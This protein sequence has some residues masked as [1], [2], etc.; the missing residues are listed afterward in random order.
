MTC[1]E[2][3]GANCLSCSNFDECEKCDSENGWDLSPNHETCIQIVVSDGCAQDNW[4]DYL[5]I[6]DGDD[7]VYQCGECEEGKYL[8]ETYTCVGCDTIDSDCVRC[9]NGL[10]CKKCVDELNLSPW[11]MECLPKI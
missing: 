9:E 2:I 1:Q 5:I 11:K 3:H 6:E 7:L 8:D 10:E 4:N